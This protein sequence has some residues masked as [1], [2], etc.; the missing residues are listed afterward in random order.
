MRRVRLF[1]SALADVRYVYGRPIS[2]PFRKQFK[3]AADH[4][5]ELDRL[6]DARERAEADER[7]R[8]AKACGAEKLAVNRDARE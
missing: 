1:E 2:I 3:S 5:A 7:A 4:K 6:D 8:W